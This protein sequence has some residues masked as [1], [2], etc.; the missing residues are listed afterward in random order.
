MLVKF[1]TVGGT[2]GVWQ[3]NIS[4]RRKSSEKWFLRDFKSWKPF[5]SGI[6][7]KRR[8]SDESLTDDC[9]IRHSWNVSLWV[10]CHSRICSSPLWSCSSKSVL[11]AG[12][13]CDP[14]CWKLLQ[15]SV[16][17]PQI[18]D[19]L[20]QSLQSSF[21]STHCLL[22]LISDQPYQ[23]RAASL[24]GADELS[25][26]PLTV[27]HCCLCRALLGHTVIQASVSLNWDWDKL[28]FFSRLTLWDSTASLSWRSF[29]LCWILCWSV[30]CVSFSCF[31]RTNGW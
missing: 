27:L 4:S 7:F 30:F 29:S 11:P 21:S 9:I 3:L 23:L 15:L 31:C 6:S 10:F 20:L 25:K 18:I 28:L 1:W 22:F 16:S 13:G 2:S 26:D 17:P 12:T 8:W 5:V 19:L 24:N 14:V